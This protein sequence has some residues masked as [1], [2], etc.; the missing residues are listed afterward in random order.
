MSDER[1]TTTTNDDGG[2]PP[3][4]GAHAPET[5]TPDAETVDPYADVPSLFEQ[6]LEI[7]TPER[8]RIRYE[9]AGIGSRFAAGTIDGLI[10]GF[11]L[12]VLLIVALVVTSLSLD[13]LEENVRFVLMAAYGLAIAVIWCFYLGFEL[14][15]DGQTPGKRLMR[16]RVVAEEGGPAPASAIIVRNVLRVAD[17]LPLVLVHALGGIVMFMSTR[18]K[19]IG[20]MAA[21]TVVVQERE[22]ELSLDRLSRGVLENLHDDQLGGEDRARLKRFV[23][24]RKELAAKSRGAVAERLLAEL[25]E[26]HELPDADPESILVL[27][28]AGKRPSELRDLG[29]PTPTAA[30][31]PSEAPDDSRADSPEGGD[32]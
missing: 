7:E 17:M 8:V 23:A 13:E 12:F 18:S 32:A 5:H 10:L 31:A 21:G 20:D 25:R 15:W 24:R 4:P 16:L 26:R 22:V 2:D 3:A 19:R 1:L 14:L 11:V 30:A 9:L 29:G 27:L 28:A 6:T